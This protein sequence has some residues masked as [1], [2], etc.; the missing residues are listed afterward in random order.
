MIYFARYLFYS[1]H[2]NCLR[3]QLR[4]RADEILGYSYDMIG[5]RRNLIKLRMICGVT[6]CG[7]NPNHARSD[8]P[9]KIT[10][11]LHLRTKANGVQFA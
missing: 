9:S 7:F 8:S 3:L 6:K 5:I 11:V 10:V 2:A 1:F 4:K